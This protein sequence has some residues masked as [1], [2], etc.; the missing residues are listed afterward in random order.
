MK[1]V[2]H[3]KRLFLIPVC[4]LIIVCI[5]AS[6]SLSEMGMTT[7]SYLCYGVTL[8]SFFSLSV[9]YLYE[10]EMSRY[11]FLVFIFLSM[12]LSATIINAQEIKGAIYTVVEIA[13]VF[14]LFKYYKKRMSVV[15]IGS[16]IGMSI[17]VYANFLHMLAHPELWSFENEKFATGYLLGN[18]Y[19]QLGCRMITAI[20]CS[21]LCLKYSKWWMLNVIPV[22]LCCILPL[23]IIRSMTSLSC[24]CLF[25][26]FC[27]IPWIRVQKIIFTAVVT[28]IILFQT[29]VVFSGKG[30]EN[31]ELAVYLVVDV[32]EKDITFT[33]RTLMWDQA[34]KVIAN[35][36]VLGYGMVDSDWFIKNMESFATG[37]HNMILATLINGGVI[38]FALYI[39]LCVISLRKLL[40]SKDRMAITLA[41]GIAALMIMMLMEM[42]PYYFIMLLLGL[43]YYYN[44]ISSQAKIKEK[45]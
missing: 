34:L 12:L 29:F 28:V 6:M 15:V 45:L 21:I 11:G 22:V 2:I 7:V 9:A 23:A 5:F 36:P 33:H 37:P 39:A 38:L 30:L 43:G 16:T 4:M 40:E 20:I 17:C 32:L 8:L 41:F 1:L 26:L 35:S 10:Q 25:L 31:N 44:Q 42:I 18:N 14:L 27:L 13:C 24:I 19:N 3:L